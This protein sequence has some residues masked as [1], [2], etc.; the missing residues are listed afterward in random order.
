MNMSDGGTPS[1]IMS[2]GFLVPEEL[3]LIARAFEPELLED[4]LYGLLAYLNGRTSHRFTGVYRF[5]PG[6]V[7]S[8][9]LFDRTNPELRVGADVKMK[10][11]YCWLTGLGGEY[12]I[13]DAC[14]DIRLTQHAA[15]D[16]VRS[17]VAV[18]IRDRDGTPW[19]T[20]C[21]YDFEPRPMADDT[22]TWL[23][24]FRPLIEEL[25]VRDRPAAWDPE[26]PSVRRVKADISDTSMLRSV[27]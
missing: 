15:R 26:A 1:A 10:E 11:S 21:H 16:A 23:S 25:F 19:G 12:I 9:A 8:V 4:D 20:L 22:L 3:A 17:Y 13:E 24:A 7:V 14:S 5:D 6:W 27:S 2:R 18:L